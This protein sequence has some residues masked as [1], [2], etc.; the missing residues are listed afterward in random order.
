MKWERLF[1]FDDFARTH[2]QIGDYEEN[3]EAISASNAAELREFPAK[4]KRLSISEHNVSLSLSG[5]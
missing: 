2:L 3:E 1:F 5:K 4:F